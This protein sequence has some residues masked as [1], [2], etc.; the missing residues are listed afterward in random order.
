[1]RLTL[2]TDYSLRLLMFAAS[3]RER[4]VTIEETART[5]GIS[6]THL[7]KVANLLTSEGY[8][9][10]V[11]GRSGGLRL[12]KD[13]QDICLG[14][15]I[16][17]T[18]PDFALVECFDRTNHCRITPRCRLRGVVSDALA[19]FLEVFDRHTLADLMINPADFGISRSRPGAT[20]TLAKSPA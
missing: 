2:F 14:D 8:L 6:R 9:E 3:H 4:L 17:V 7:M 13:P 5:F 18:E 20:P 19:A 11:R 1:M 10:A 15:V 12:V 16:R